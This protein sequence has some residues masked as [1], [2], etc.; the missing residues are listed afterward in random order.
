MKQQKAIKSKNISENWWIYS[1]N[2]Q[3]FSQLTRIIVLGILV[4]MFCSYH[5]L[6]KNPGLVDQVKDIFTYGMY[7]YLA[8]T[9]QYFFATVS[10]NI[11]ARLQELGYVNK[12]IRPSEVNYPAKIFYV[13]KYFIFL[14]IVLRFI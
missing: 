11:L 9:A 2:S 10:Y 4:L 12:D 14:Y 8:D 1:Q 5:L 3:I 6:P 7:Y 13:L